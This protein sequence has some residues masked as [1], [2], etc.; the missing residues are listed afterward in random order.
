MEHR[1][2]KPGW[3]KDVYPTQ[4]FLHSSKN[5]ELYIGELDGR[6]VSCMVANHAYNNG[7]K[8]VQWSVDAA[9]AKSCLPSTPL[10]F[11]PISPAGASPSRW[12][13]M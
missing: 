13:G 2:F 12:S 1:E 11:I 6:M 3:E 9:D 8:Q 4:D 7:Y 10:V 5:A